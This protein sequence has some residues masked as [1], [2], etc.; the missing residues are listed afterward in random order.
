MYMP[1][2]SN[3]ILKI[4]GYDIVVENFNDDF[5]LLRSAEDCKVDLPVLGSAIFKRQF[6][7]VAEVIAAETEICLKLN[8]RFT[9]QGLEELCSLQE[10]RPLSGA[11][12]TC[13][14]M[15]IW[16]SDTDDWDLVCQHTGLI[17][18]DYIQQLAEQR[19]QVAMLG[20]LPGF[21]YLKGLAEHLQVPRKANPDRSTEANSFA[22]G[23]TYAGIYSLPSPAGWNV[24]GRI[25]VPVMQTDQL[26]PVILQPGDS[27]RIQ[28]IERTEYEHLLRE[29]PTLIDDN[30]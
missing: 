18:S 22:V 23:G 9:Q 30:G 6:E 19:L 26:P 28:P 7:F 21:V 4:A 27:I 5:L 8:D 25:A 14:S 15:P 24:I 3:T 10:K 1:S 16:F 20:F 2:N 29:R 13:Y 12:E 11:I 17:R